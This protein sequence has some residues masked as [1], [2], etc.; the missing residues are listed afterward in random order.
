METRPPDSPSVLTDYEPPT[1][2]GDR[3][4]LHVLLFVAT[5]ASMVWCGGILAAR[6]ALWPEVAEG[7]SDTVAML[8]L[9]SSRSFLTDGF[10]YAVP[11]LGFLTVHEFGHYLAARWRRTRVSLPY[12]LP[13]PIPGTLG[14][15]GAVIRI[16]EPLRRTQQL[17]DIGA[18]GPLAGANTLT[19]SSNL[20]SLVCVVEN[21]EP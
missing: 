8:S 10:L 18:A 17:F 6:M 13:I 12:Y 4:W 20:A 21:P 14:T 1:P 19:S 15:F 2:D 9:L 7:T 3:V 16:K 11:F 5:F